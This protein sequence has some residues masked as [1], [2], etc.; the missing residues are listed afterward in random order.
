MAAAVVVISDDT[1]PVPYTGEAGILFPLLDEMIQAGLDPQSRVMVREYVQ[2]LTPTT[3]VILT[4]H[5][6]DEADRLAD[7][8]AIM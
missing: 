1:R 7:R 2:S 4:T 6:M 3:T 5:D 8:V